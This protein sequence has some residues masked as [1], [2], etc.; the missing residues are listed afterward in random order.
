VVST[1]TT[2]PSKGSYQKAKDLLGWEPNLDIE[3]LVKKVAKEIVI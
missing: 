2:R 1:E 3:S